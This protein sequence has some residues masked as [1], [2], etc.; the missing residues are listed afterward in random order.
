MDKSF[1]DLFNEF[2]KRNNI[3]PD[4]ELNDDLEGT[5]RKIIEMLTNA[6]N[7]DSFDE[8]LEMEIDKSL[9]KPDKIE[10]Y[11]EGDMFFEKR[12]WSTE[13]GD[14][15]KIIVTDEPTL[16]M[17]PEMERPLEEQLEEAVE[18]EEFEKAAAIRDLI[19]KEKRKKTRKKSK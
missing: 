6:N 13:N 14:I 3:N 15:V 12:I 18:A 4:D 10:F 1:N 9:G 8:N 7:I 17:P 19:K 11:N 2:F 16:N 5:A